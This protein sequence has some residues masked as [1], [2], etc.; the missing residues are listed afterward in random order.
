MALKNLLNATCVFYRF[1]LIT[2]LAT[3]I[4]TYDLDDLRLWYFI[5]VFFFCKEIILLSWLQNGSK[6]LSKSFLAYSIA[7]TLLVLSEMCDKFQLNQIIQKCSHLDR[8]NINSSNNITENL[9]EK[10]DSRNINEN[11]LEIVNNISSSNIT[12]NMKCFETLNNKL[13]F[14]S[15]YKVSDKIEAE[16]I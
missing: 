3:S 1:I 4:F 2:L 14:K 6:R 7:M 10:I 15:K 12:E 16:V 13:Y 11:L 8:L 5:S 9:I